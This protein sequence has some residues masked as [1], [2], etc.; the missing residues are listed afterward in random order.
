VTVLTVTLIHIFN[1]LELLKKAKLK[2]VN[3]GY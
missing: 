2:L 3:K 1:D